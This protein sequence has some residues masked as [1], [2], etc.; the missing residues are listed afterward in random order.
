MSCRDL[1][2]WPGNPVGPAV[3]ARAHFPLARTTLSVG[4]SQTDGSKSPR[5]RG[6]G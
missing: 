1:Q 2:D 4:C 5:T 3:T 6:V